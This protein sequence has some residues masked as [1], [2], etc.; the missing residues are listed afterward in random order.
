MFKD[1]NQIMKQAREMQ[2]RMQVLQEELGRREL[3]GRAGGG[4]VIVTLNGRGELLRVQ[5]DP[6]AVGDVEMLED[7]VASAFR[8][9]H[10]QVQE[11]AQRELGG[12]GGLLGGLPGA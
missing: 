11:L 1:L 3:Q 5:I 12:L 4:M 7:L 10:R 2:A 9:A 6:Q 8:D